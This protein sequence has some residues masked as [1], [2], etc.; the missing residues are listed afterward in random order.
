[1]ENKKANLK[2]K[3]F[4]PPPPPPRENYLNK[5]KINKKSISPII[6]TLL[7]ITVSVVLG[8]SMY[9]WY[10]EYTRTIS[11]DIGDKGFSKEI[12][13][14]YINQN[15]IYAFNEYT[16]TQIKSISVDGNECDLVDSN[17]NFSKGTIQISFDESC[18][19]NLNSNINEVVVVSDKG[20]YSTLLSISNSNYVFSNDDDSKDSNGGSEAIINYC[21]SGSF[22]YE[23]VLFD[24][25]DIEDGLTKNIVEVDSISGG[26][27]TSY[28]DI[29][30]NYPGIDY[31][32]NT[33]TSSVVCDAGYLLS[34]LE[35]SCELITSC[36]SGDYSF[37]GDLFSYPFLDSGS[38][39]VSV[40]E[41]IDS[42]LVLSKNLGL[43]C[44][45]TIVSNTSYEEV[46][47]CLDGYELEGSMNVSI[48]FKDHYESSSYIDGSYMISTYSQNGRIYAVVTG[49]R[50]DEFS[51]FDITNPSNIIFKDNYQS[52]TYI[53]SPQG[54][55]TYSQNEN[56]YTVVTG[57]EG[58]EFSVFDITNPSNIIFKDNYQSSTYIDYSHGVST[59]SQN[60]NIYTIITGLYGDE[61]S[62]FD[63]TNPSNIIFKDNYQSST[64]IDGAF[65][66]S[67]YSQNGNM[68]AVVT[69][70]SGDEFS[71]FD[72]TNPSNIIFKDN[73]QSSTY[74]YYPWSVST[75]SQNENVYTVVTGAEGDEF[76][77]FDITNPSNIIFKDNYQSSTYIN[78]PRGISTYNENGNR[79]V[80]IIGSDKDQFSVF[81]ITNP[82]NIIFK[83]SYESSTHIDNPRYIST[84]SQ[85]GNMYA[86]VTGYSGDEF[87]V[88]ELKHT[89][90]EP[91]C[92]L[93][94]SKSSCKEILEN[95]PN[96]QSGVYTINPD[97]TN[98]FEVYCDMETDGGGWTKIASVIQTKTTWTLEENWINEN[99]FGT[100]ENRY[101][102]DYKNEFYNEKVNDI[103]YKTSSGAN[104]YFN[105]CLNDLTLSEKFENSDWEE[106][107][108]NVDGSFYGSV[109]SK[110]GGF[111]N[112]HGDNLFFK[113]YDKF[114]GGVHGKS[115]LSSK[116]YKENHRWGLIGLGV[117][118][119]SHYGLL[120][121]H[122]YSGGDSGAHKDF[123][124]IDRN[125]DY[126]FIFIR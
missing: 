82:S 100:L 62:V 63:I 122:K 14:D 54:I 36:S 103:M 43:L 66:V 79:Y 24:Y 39:Y 67:T 109:C 118:E 27:K 83:N 9:D 93:E 32:S 49:E 48:E 55:S 111:N 50:A 115:M 53:N 108:A 44:E 77:V 97:G 70:R 105:N 38:E 65:G 69:G 102:E 26:S 84:Y 90:E 56:V 80:T 64:Y 119:S 88:F 71:V 110:S 34:S 45:N 31:D 10:S 51:V 41:E 95:N 68:Y 92:K 12:R 17:N 42:N 72:I 59:Y 22:T 101:S 6:A 85:N 60:G 73:Y 113:I 15:T 116:T 87:S 106:N 76:S 99:T 37:N 8:V 94:E 91:Y 52:S 121:N 112:G 21:L 35:D 104:V 124:H 123:G 7:I 89:E 23:N 1:M 4:T 2:S 114:E 33:F 5:N 28:I 11:S 3:Q 13:I 47:G 98:E 30:C 61:F 19:Q 125:V 126:T 58:D 29:T 78:G 16:K 96:S 120:N 75:Y 20:T 25:L 81:D 46:L 40:I 74:I 18:T 107:V 86:L 117:I 57:A